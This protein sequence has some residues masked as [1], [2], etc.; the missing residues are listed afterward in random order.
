MK[1][2]NKCGVSKN[3]SDFHRMAKS[4][5][6]M[7]PTCKQC[8]S[9]RHRRRY[10]E[11]K[12]AIMTKNAEWRET[13]KAQ[14]KEYERVRYAAMKEKKANNNAEYRRQNGDRLRAYDRQRYTSRRGAVIES[15]RRRRRGVA[16]ASPPWLTVAQRREIENVYV[17]AR[18]C[19]VVTGEPYHVDHIVPL[20]STMVC[21]LH[22]PWNLQVLPSSVNDSKGNKFDGGW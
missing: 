13:N 10:L 8:V 12:E 7:H 3:P 21:G 6:G 5:D 11:N 15:V 14:R 19:S 16:K 20:R 4:K 2:C 17:L 22:V 1:T 9:Y 18:D